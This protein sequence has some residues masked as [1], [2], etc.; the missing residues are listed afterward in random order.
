MQFYKLQASGNDFLVVEEKNL[1]PNASLD[2]LAER[3]CDRHYG[4]G[5]DG[6]L[7]VWPRVDRRPADV[8]MRIFNADGSEAEISGNGLRCVAAYLYYTG[9]WSE[10]EVRIETKVGVRTIRQLKAQGHVYELEV[11]MG[12]P[13]LA[14]SDIPMD[15]EPPMPRVVKHPLRV[16]EDVFHIT[17]C[18]MGNPHCSLILRDIDRIDFT[19]IGSRIE[20]HAI[21]PERTNVEFVKVINRSRVQVLFWERGVGETLSSGS[22]SCAAAIAAMLNGRADRKVHV[23]T[24]AGELIVHWRDDGMVVLIGPAEVVCRGEWLTDVS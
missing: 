6:L 13:R 4:A 18:S 19:D 1:P 11:G 14:S 15:L 21:F 12:R 23:Q 5:A 20:N 16:G 10:P 17:A 3:W 8:G 22:G 2:L 24:R 7:I 9:Q